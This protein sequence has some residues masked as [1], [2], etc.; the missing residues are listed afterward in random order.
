MLKNFSFFTRNSRIPSKKL[1]ENLKKATRNYAKRQIT[2]FK[3]DLKINWIYVDDFEN[4]SDILN[5]A[6]KIIKKFIN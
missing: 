1:K 3:R 5:K 2:W 6:E 4:Y